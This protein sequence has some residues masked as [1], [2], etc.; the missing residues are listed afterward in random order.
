MSTDLAVG[1]DRPW[2]RFRQPIERN[3]IKNGL[4]GKRLVNPVEK[5]LA[6]PE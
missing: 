6:T 2:K 1:V 3:E 4:G 5:L